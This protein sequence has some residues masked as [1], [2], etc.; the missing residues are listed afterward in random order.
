VAVISKKISLALLKEGVIGRF[1]IDF[2]SVKE[3]K[4]V[5]LCNRNQSAERRHH[6]PFLNA[7]VSTEGVYDWENGIYK[8]PNGENR[9]YFASDNLSNDIYKG[10]TP[11][12]LIIILPYAIKL[13]Y[14]GVTQSGVMFHMIGALSQYGKMGVVCIVK[15]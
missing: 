4:M 11:P 2:L 9:C 12:D 8:M 7:A 10:I 6:T 3:R 1:S 15:R 14:N 5:S 13:L